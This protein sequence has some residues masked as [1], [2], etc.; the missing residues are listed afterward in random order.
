MASSL[1][2]NKPVQK[3]LSFFKKLPLGNCRPWASSIKI[4]CQIFF[5]L[6][7]RLNLFT[8]LCHCPASASSFSFLSPGSFLQ[9]VEE[10][11]TWRP[12]FCPQE[13]GCRKN[14]SSSTFP[15]SL[16][17]SCLGTKQQDFRK[18]F[19]EET[20]RPCSAAADASALLYC[21]SLPWSRESVSPSTWLEALLSPTWFYLISSGNL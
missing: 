1:L 2:C 13:R 4:W 18:V 6:F 12:F 10:M 7:I 3:K 9:G 11:Q 15:L 16:F 19:Q 20:Y 5:L 8:I 14:S 21:I 17:V